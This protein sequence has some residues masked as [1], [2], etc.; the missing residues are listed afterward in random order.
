M[1]Q[2]FIIPGGNS[3]K[4]SKE[5]FDYYMENLERYPYRMFINWSFG[6]NYGSYMSLPN[7][8]D[9]HAPTGDKLSAVE[10]GL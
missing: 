3:V 1:R 10:I 5:I 6:K 4:K 8:D 7:A 9:S 2:I